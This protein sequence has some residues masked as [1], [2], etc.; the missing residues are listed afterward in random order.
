MKILKIILKSVHDYTHQA[1]I[2]MVYY[3]YF[4]Y[5]QWIFARDKKPNMRSM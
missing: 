3:S 5:S 1:K 2:I 4:V